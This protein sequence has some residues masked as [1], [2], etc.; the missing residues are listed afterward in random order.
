MD[1]QLKRN[2]KANQSK[3]AVDDLWIYSFSLQTLVTICDA[4]QIL[5]NFNIVSQPNLHRH[6]VLLNVGKFGRLLFVHPFY[7][8]GAVEA[9]AMLNVFS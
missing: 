9:F 4:R 5:S 3:F 2:S 7:A 6:T 1:M 8:L